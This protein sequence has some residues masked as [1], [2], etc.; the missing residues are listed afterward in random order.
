ME[1]S[2]C[3]CIILALLL[4]MGVLVQTSFA[5]YETTDPWPMWRHDLERTGST[6]ST[7]PN[8]NFTL[9]SSEVFY[10]TCTPIVVNGKVFVTGTGQ[11]LYALDE[12]TGVTLW[13]SFAFSGSPGGNIAYSDG[14]LYVGTNN[15]Y[16]YSI[17]AT[18]GT[19]IHEYN[20]SPAQVSTTPAVA[21]GKVFF[22][23]TNNNLYALNA[24]T[25]LLK[26]YYT[27]GGP[28][29][30]SPTIS[31]NMLFFGC[32]DFKVYGLDIS[33]DAGATLKW[34]YTTGGI[35]RCSPCVG[36]GK[37]FIGS[38]SSDHA[39]FALNA[40]TTNPNGEKIWNW[41]MIQGYAIENS[42][43]FYNDMLYVTAP[44]QKVAA[45]YA[46]GF[47]GDFA[48]N[49]P[50]KKWSLSTEVGTYPSTASVADGKMFFGANDKK[51]YAV[52]IDDGGMVWTH[53][54]AGYYAPGEPIVA[55]GRLFVVKYDAIHCIGDYYPPL[56]YYYTVTPPGHTYVIELVIANATPGQTIDISRL[57]ALKKINFTVTGID[58]TL[59]ACNITIPDEMLGGDYDVRI[60]GGL[61]L[62]PPGLVVTHINGTHTSLYFSYY[63]SVNAIE[64]TGTT[65]I[66]EFSQIIALP[67]LITILLVAVAL[68]RKRTR[69]N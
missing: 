44:Y 22:G 25:L 18:T 1:K 29:Y 10:P 8:S 57:V 43:V 13:Q 54:F 58:G 17:N 56:T 12:T 5:L 24:S 19:K 30:S 32:D 31:G 23:A 36:S 21:N 9:W 59:G 45:L 50:I 3:F 16:L 40:T 46:S 55:D 60:N 65:A 51:L 63:Q 62:V 64:I 2:I 47:T 6:T 15:G 7:A 61:P 68:A 37:V 26:W 49:G 28:I 11:K 20:I 33:S 4:V 34:R 27:A 66:P 35:I 42:P 53:T 69:Q 41:T 67:S 52:N 39:I 48:E 38:S 14:I